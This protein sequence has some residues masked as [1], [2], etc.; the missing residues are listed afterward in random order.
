MKYMR[1][2]CGYDLND[3]SKEE[4]I[5]LN[6]KFAQVMAGVRKETK[7]RRCLFCG[8]EVSSLCNS[9]TIPRFCLESIGIDGEVAGSNSI[10]GLPQMGLSIGKENLGIN[11]SGTFRLICRDCDSTIFQD[12]ENPNNYTVVKPPTQNM[13]AEIAMKNYLKFIS[14]RIIEI[15]LMENGLKTTLNNGAR[16]PLLIKG[17][18]SK[19]DVSELDLDAYYESFTKAKK[20]VETGKGKGYFLFYYKIL[21]YVSPIAIQAPI[22]VSIDLEG[23]VVNDILNMNSTNRIVDLHLCVLPMDAKTVVMLF[24][25]EGDK[26]YGK[27]R[28]QFKKLDEESQLGVINYLIFLYSE[29]YFMSKE[30]KNMIDLR[31]INDL[32]NL[33]PMILSSSPIHD[34]RVLA[35][36][37]SL[38]NWNSIPNLLSEKYQLKKSI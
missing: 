34:T 12:Y 3:I 35:D 4:E 28:K 8:R 15:S 23:N 29:D 16:N 17:F 10:L 5:E 2:D 25:D 22:A 18:L 32:A 33:T 6:K 20:Y 14:K 7:P 21:D 27:F 11:Q 31:K 1:V 13:L 19:L 26:H 24:V 30:V 36:R 37:F 9:H 38:A